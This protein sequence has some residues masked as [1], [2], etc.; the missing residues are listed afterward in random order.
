MHF[1]SLLLI[2]LVLRYR[3]HW[4]A[5][6][7]NDTCFHFLLAISP[8]LAWVKFTLTTAL[9]SL[10][11]LMS[12]HLLDS[13]SLGL[14][15]LILTSLL[16]MY[17]LGRGHFVSLFKRYRNACDKQDMDELREILYILA[18][19]EN[20]DNFCQL[21][22]KIKQGFIYR[23]LTH[24]FAVL[25]W[26]AA[27]GPAAAVFYRLNQL[28]IE[29]EDNALSCQV[30]AWMEWPAARLFAFSAA[31][32]GNFNAAID[33]CKSCLGNHK[34]TAPAIVYTASELALGLDK[35][36]WFAS[37]FTV[38]HDEAEIFQLAIEETNEI[39]QLLHRCLILSV[40]C[41]AL[42]HIIF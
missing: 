33:Y 19:T 37:R 26:F 4:L 16:L 7:Q 24:L 27:F 29:Q 35:R 20:A 18:P 12:L 22:V 15:E 23:A 36:D 9:P 2:L 39:Q 42:L 21:H 11:L 40:V 1:I 6:I 10:L 13:F 28:L 3:R 8:N 41:I 38:E 14:F 5:R 31:L 17:A 34:N 25:F 30:I 32:L